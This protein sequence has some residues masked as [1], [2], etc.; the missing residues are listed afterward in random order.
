MFMMR[1]R[2]GSKLEREIRRLNA[3][4]YRRREASVAAVTA[5]AEEQENA[6]TVRDHPQHAV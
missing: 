6:R 4:A 3:Q 5:H 1:D 2:E